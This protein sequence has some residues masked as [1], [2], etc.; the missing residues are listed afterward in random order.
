LLTSRIS[1]CNFV[2]IALVTFFASVCLMLSFA[3]FV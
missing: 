3:D 2:T 1:L